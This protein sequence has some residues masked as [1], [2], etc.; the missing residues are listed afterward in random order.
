MSSA[1][2]VVTIGPLKPQS[3][4]VSPCLSAPLA[5]M[6]STVWPRPSTTLTSSTVACGS[7]AHMSRCTM[8]VCVSLTISC[9]MSGMPSP[10]IAEVGTIEMFSR[11]S[12]LRQ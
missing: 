12:P 6:M 10:V 2:T 4:M 1:R 8:K 3:T 11:K 5:R 9:S 7:R